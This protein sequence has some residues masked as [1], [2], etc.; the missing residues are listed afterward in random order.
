MTHLGHRTWVAQRKARGRLFRL[1]G[2]SALFAWNS[3]DAHFIC[4][5]SNGLISHGPT[6]NPLFIG[7]VMKDHLQSDKGSSPYSS[8]S[9]FL[10]LLVA[11]IFLAYKIDAA[12]QL[13]HLAH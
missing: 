11:G 12:N 4:P 8:L 9:C 1:Y 10:L 2:V 3:Y 5:D 6:R 7:A 13:L